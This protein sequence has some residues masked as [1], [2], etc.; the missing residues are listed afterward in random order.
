MNSF[1]TGQPVVLFIHNKYLYQ[2]GEDSVVF[3]EM[4]LLK[5]AGVRVFY[6]EYNNHTFSKKN[7]FALPA[8]GLRFFFNISSFFSVYRFI[9]RNQVNTVHVHNFFYN[10]SPSVFWAAKL[11]GAVTVFS[12]HNY[13]LFCLN[14]LFFRA[15]GNCMDCVNNKS[16]KPGIRHKCFKSSSLLSRILAG[17]TMLHRNIGTWRNKVDHFLVLN[18]LMKSLLV[19]TGVNE[20][21]I[22]VKPN[23]LSWHGYTD[24]SRR[25]DFYLYIGRLDEVKGIRHVFETFRSSGKKLVI[26]GEGELV[27]YIRSGLSENIEYLGQQTKE[28]IVS[29][30]QRCRAFIFSSL[31]LEGMPMTI[32]EAQAAGAITIAGSSPTTESMIS[33]AANGFLYEAG[34]QASLA[35]AISRLEELQPETLNR[36]SANAYS[37]YMNRYHEN[38]HLATL[39]QVY[40]RG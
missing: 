2:G 15:G 30:L 6:K 16:F 8:A 27:S 33:D 25:E 28:E 39:R 10:A 7:L 18:P 35:A 17:A 12:V 4:D 21:K 36:I 9:R 26:A 19:Q 22:H 37:T 3:N 29:L 40:E 1:F 14:A 13:R 24:Y 5:K 11:A 23:F 31:L 20:E 34:N 32:I 38:G